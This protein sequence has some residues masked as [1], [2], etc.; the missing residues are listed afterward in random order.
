MISLKHRIHDPIPR[1]EIIII[2][3]NYSNYY[4]TVNHA[5]LQGHYSEPLLFTTTVHSTGNVILV[6]KIIS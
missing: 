6:H 4:C 5:V 3:R 2:L 1:V